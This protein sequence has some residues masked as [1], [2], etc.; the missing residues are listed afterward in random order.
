MEKDLLPLAR[1]GIMV[2]ITAS[3]YYYTKDTAVLL[4]TNQWKKNGKKYG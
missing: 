2:Y 1:M 4:L 3:Y